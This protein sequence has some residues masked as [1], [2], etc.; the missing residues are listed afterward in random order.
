MGL[1]DNLFDLALLDWGRLHP[2]PQPVCL[3][4]MLTDMEVQARP[5]M[6]DKGLRLRLR[7][8]RALQCASV[9]TDRVMM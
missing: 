3:Y 7:T 1:F 4:E 2:V 6:H 8:S 5:A 9:T